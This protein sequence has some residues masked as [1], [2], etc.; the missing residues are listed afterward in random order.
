MIKA[1][2][3]P[4]PTSGI[5]LD[6]AAEFLDLL[7]AK[8]PTFQ[9]FDDDKNRKDAK[10][11]R[12]RHGA[13]DDLANDL[14]ALNRRG[15]GI[16]FCVNQTNG[17][18][19]KRENIIRV[20][21]VW[22][23]LDGPPVDPVLACP[24]KPHV[25]TQTSQGRYQCFWRVE[26]DFPLEHFHTVQYAIARAFDG[27]TAAG[28]LEGCARL[29]GFLHR[30]RE[31]FLVQI[32]EAH[33]GPA[34]NFDELI[35]QFPPLARPHKPA[36]S[37]VVLPA[38][39]PLVCAAEFV[40]R[41]FFTKSASTLHFYRGAFYDWRKTHYGEREAKFI[42]SELYQFLSKALVETREGD[43]IPFNPKRNKVA[44]IL[45][46]LESGVYLDR[47][48]N[49]PMWLPPTRDLSADLVACCNG[50]LDVESRRLIPHSPFFFNVNRLPFDFD[51]GA[52]QGPRWDQFLRELW[53][54]D[55][56]ARTT[57]QE[58][59][60]L[61]LTADT[62]FQKIFLV[63]GPRR[64]GKGTIGHVLT[65][66]LGR[67][68]VAS[69]TMASLASH[70]G[71]WPLID[72]RLAIVPD[73]RLSGRD[74]NKA[75]EHLLSVS[76]EDALTIDR[77]Y[78]V[79][80]TGKLSARFLMLTNE[81]PRFADASGALASRF[82]ILT[83]RRSFYGHEELGL[84]EKLRGELPYILNWALAGLARLRA[85]GYF[86]LP[87]SS[88]DAMKM[89]EDLASPVGAFVR[90][91]CAIEPTLRVEKAVLYREW[92]AWCEDQGE[93]PSSARMFGRNLCA[94]FAQVRPTHSGETK[95]YAGIGL[96]DDNDGDETPLGKAAR[97]SRSSDD[98]DDGYE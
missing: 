66:L 87:R 95:C 39:K 11:A 19:R 34:Y 70:F 33:D 46:A 20:R 82:V 12:V 42:R 14:C 53:P 77:K 47:D 65:E 89:M 26:K 72:K 10:L 48:L 7:G 50:L 5:D 57:L 29:V 52:D 13:L 59:F 1:N 98:D 38:D 43:L 62:S 79:H 90:E 96:I 80:W 74:V 91:K 8:Y 88:L 30:K 73:A 58:I 24:L 94:A 78:Q 81:L 71:L 54:D 51:P 15:A 49:T 61:M 84:K 6:A 35:A 9:T 37:V 63:V 31:P 40:R 45:D 83:L 93:K 86:A 56:E 27:D 3:V 22:A 60:G 97:R 41:T 36:G 32:V 55:D 44:E 4:R 25:V 85:R 28:R 92:K 75:V 64:S 17:R 2:L 23:D 69:P 67:E 76:G 18:G 16:F 68:N 21:A